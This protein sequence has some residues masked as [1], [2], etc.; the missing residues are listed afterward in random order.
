MILAAGISTAK[1]A[2]DGS[3]FLDL[4]GEEP[5]ERSVKM[6]HLDQMCNLQTKW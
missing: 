1:I 3:F 5:G 2:L 6:C 4:M